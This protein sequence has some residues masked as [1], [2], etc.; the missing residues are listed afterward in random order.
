MKHIEGNKK[1]VENFIKGDRKQRYESED[2][3]KIGD[4]IRTV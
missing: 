4:Y 2:N 1:C 3:I